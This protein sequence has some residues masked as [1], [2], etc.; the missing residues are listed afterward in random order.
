MKLVILTFYEGIF[1]IVGVAISVVAYF[2]TI[3]KMKELP[4]ATRRE[5]KIKPYRLFWY[6]AILLLVYMPTLIDKYYRIHDVK[7]NT[8]MTAIHLSLSRFVGVYNALVYGLQR[9][10]HYQRES[11]QSNKTEGSVPKSSMI[12]KSGASI[13][14]HLLMALKEVN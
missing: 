14:E 5:L 10:N 11:N 12:N 7:S 2:F 8:W 13:D 6:P 3:K 1:D 4:S 9:R